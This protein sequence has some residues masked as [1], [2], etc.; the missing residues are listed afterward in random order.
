MVWVSKLTIG[1]GSHTGE[2]S[3]P[4]VRSFSSL[5]T[6]SSYISQNSRLQ[7][8]GPA[9]VAALGLGVW[10]GLCGR[11]LCESIK[12][13]EIPV[14]GHLR[15]LLK[16][17]APPHQWSFPAKR[18]KACHSKQGQQCEKNGFPS[19]AQCLRS[20]AH[21]SSLHHCSAF[22]CR[23]LVSKLPVCC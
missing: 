19:G 3:Q 12:W 21:K 5:G 4:S 14:G 22:S 1:L 8:W 7:V 23:A 16:L 10:M 11:R 9:V 20:S 2:R 15:I 6:Y 18:E 13:H 17:F